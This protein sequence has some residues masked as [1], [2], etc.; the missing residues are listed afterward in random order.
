MSSIVNA[1]YPKSE[2]LHLVLEAENIRIV[3]DK[4]YNHF[5]SSLVGSLGI[6]IATQAARIVAKTIGLRVRWGIF[7]C[8]L[9]RT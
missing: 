7:H 6:D 9:D 4:I 1:H 5:I 3:L 2:V 8:R